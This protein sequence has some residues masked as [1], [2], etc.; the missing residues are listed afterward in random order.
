MRKSIGQTVLDS[1][2]GALASTGFIQ[3]LSVLGIGALLGV[4]IL[5]ATSLSDRLAPL[6]ILPVLCVFVVMI[7][8]NIEKLLVT[9]ILLDIPF[10]LDANIG[11]REA[12]GKVG[13]VAGF[14]ISLT[15]LCL[16]ILYGLWLVDILISS[17]R[18][19]Q[20]RSPSSIMAAG[21]PFVIQ[22]VGIIASLIA[23]RDTELWAFYAFLIGQMLFVALYIIKATRSGDDVS[24]MIS[25]LLVGLIVESIIIILMRF[26]GLNLSIAGIGNRI[27]TVDLTRIGGTVG[28]PNTAGAYLAFL[29]PV[30]ASMLFT[31]LKGRYKLLAIV[32]LILGSLALVFTLS[33][34]GWTAFAIAI[35]LLVLLAASRRLISFPLLVVMLVII[36]LL[37]LSFQEVIL[38]RL[39]GDDQGAAYA[40]LPLMQ[41]AFRVIGD[42]PI[43]G[44]GANNF[45][46]VLP[47]YS[48]PEFGQ[49]WLYTVHNK[50]LLIWAETGT[51]GFML[52]V[53]LLLVTLYRGWR[54]WRLKDPLLS[55]L[56]MGFTVAIIGH[57]THMLVEIFNG[58]PMTQLLWISA[59]LLTGIH[60][61]S[62]R[63]VR[64]RA[65][66]LQLYT[67]SLPPVLAFTAIPHQHR[68]TTAPMTPFVATLAD[69]IEQGR[70]KLTAFG[71]RALRV[72]RNALSLI[73]SDIVNR[74]TTF[75]LYALVGRYLGT[76]EF[77]QLSL[78]LS[79][80][81]PAQVL[82][83]AGMR[84][85]VTRE[86]AKDRS[87][88]GEILVNAS[89]VVTLTSILSIA[90][91]LIF[92]R[93]MNYSSETTLVIFIVSLALLPDVLSF[94]CEAALQAWEQMHFIAYANI[95]ANII[96][97]VLA[98]LVITNG[99]GLH[100]L[101]LALLVTQ[102]II[103]V[104]DWTFLYRKIVKPRLRI[105]L[106]Q[107]WEMFKNTST[108]LGINVVIA[109]AGAVDT[110]LLSRLT[111]EA[112][113]GLV[114]AAKQIM[115][116]V[117]LTFQSIMLAFFPIMV[118]RFDTGISGLK[119]ISER[120]LEV[121]LTVSL[122]LM[123]GIFFLADHVILLLY[124]EPDFLPAVLALRI[125]VFGVALQ[126][127]TTVLGHVLYA[128]LHE[129][130]TLQIVWLNLLLTF[131]IGFIFTS[132]FGF[133]GAAITMLLI[134][135][136][137]FFQHYRSVSRLLGHVP[138]I[139]PLWK[140]A[141]A[142]A[143]MALY[144]VLTADQTNIITVA[145]AGFIYVIVWGGLAVWSMGG[146]E[147]LRTDYQRLFARG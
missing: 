27:D 35:V 127:F 131:V 93:L 33:R 97:V 86:V 102:T 145:F 73:T 120:L 34:G 75:V 13:A 91:L 5:I 20:Q 116:P 117:L 11:W 138:I 134:R 129:K 92:A 128:S 124:G 6:A 47:Q 122:P 101:V 77:G 15:T 142:G 108:F 64:T 7:V 40:R 81:Y 111:N 65:Q 137:D 14:S 62:M 39:F 61:I 30:A 42:Y 57:T 59:A 60:M 125:M 96:K 38:G 98:F 36:G 76:Q 53:L 118:R 136:V 144:L 113:V 133:V 68:H 45:S 112:Q 130:R 83:N 48:T 90:I 95:P 9:V 105:D 70:L 43:V 2:N 94:T 21:W 50:F 49:E 69:T 132:Q 23:A 3:W 103:L 143:F 25:I 78:A 82:A 66:Q 29:L 71:Q 84:T 52:F 58:R 4:Y 99:L 19:Y 115:V 41:L 63:L 121:L 79:L 28:S 107:C 22:L 146:I 139:E 12:A 123:I 104:I 1:Y 72:M 74:A 56:A 147:Q 10:Q 17:K 88:T 51:V 135:I 8:G 37:A 110:I 16:I 140:P 18:G 31:P 89:M 141:I 119:K 32:A 46:I 55:P 44:V 106:R 80:Y 85:Y 126:V 100:W 24:F 109:I 54:G 26:T 114:G 87:K 67:A